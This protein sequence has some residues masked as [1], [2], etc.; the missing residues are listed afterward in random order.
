MEPLIVQVKSKRK[1]GYIVK[2]LLNY[3]TGKGTVQI[4]DPIQN[5]FDD[6]TVPSDGAI[7]GE[8]KEVTATNLVT[9]VSG[10]DVSARIIDY[11]KNYFRNVRAEVPRARHGDPMTLNITRPNAQGQ[12]FVY[13]SQMK[14]GHGA[15]YCGWTT[16]HRARLIFKY[17]SNPVARFDRTIL[18]FALENLLSSPDCRNIVWMYCTPFDS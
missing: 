13:E 1:G 16:I 4:L 7:Y 6:V 9:S 8:L 15:L 2:Y 12:I 14:P 17:V 11:P 5:R 3:N 10:F 18:E